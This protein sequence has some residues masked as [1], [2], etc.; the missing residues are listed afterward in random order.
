MRTTI[1]RLAGHG[2]VAG[3][4]VTVLGAGAALAAPASAST[5]SGSAASANYAVPVSDVSA[6]TAPVSTVPMN[7]G[8]AN[9]A[10][11]AGVPR[12]ATAQLRIRLRYS[13]S[14]AGHHYYNLDFANAASR[15]C[16]LGGFPGVSATDA[17]GRQLGDSAGRAYTR[18]RRYV[19]IPPGGTAN[20]ILDVAVAQNFPSGCDPVIARYLKVY[21]PADTASALV[22]FGGYAC[23]HKGY[24][25]LEITRLAPGA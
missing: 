3:I 14:G 7:P 12:C 19:T 23:G 18:P 20:A 5:V 13:N 8:P 10:V 4:A 15:A 16:Y 24:Q 21:P 6:G 1:R 17:G 25:Y 2:T 11:P 9:A 22:P